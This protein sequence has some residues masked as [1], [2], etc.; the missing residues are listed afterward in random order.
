M[1]GEK[2]QEIYFTQKV[3]SI[4]LMKQKPH[5]NVYWQ[6]HSIHV[7]TVFSKAKDSLSIKM[8]FKD[9]VVY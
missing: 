9:S 4:V 5:K 8:Y 3:C 7:F 6:V 2:N 1:L